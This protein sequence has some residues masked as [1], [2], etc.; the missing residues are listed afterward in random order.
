MI[1]SVTRLADSAL[2]NYPDSLKYIKEVIVKEAA[3]RST[4]L[5]ITRL[6]EIIEE[7]NKSS[8]IGSRTR[9]FRDKWIRV[10]FD[11]ATTQWRTNSP[12]HR[13]LFCGLYNNDFSLMK[14]WG[15]IAQGNI[16]GTWVITLKGLGFLLGMPGYRYIHDRIWQLGGK[17]DNYVLPSCDY[18]PVN[19]N[20]VF[21]DFWT[22]T[23]IMGESKQELTR[24]FN[25][26]KLEEEKNA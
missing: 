16:K 9:K 25:Y 19:I 4:T 1:N 17:K 5:A 23:F 24:M 11:I 10:L 21:P 18:S 20:D 2:E 12:V 7:Q 14:H 13:S 22:P 15:L 6:L 26:M 3:H 8:V